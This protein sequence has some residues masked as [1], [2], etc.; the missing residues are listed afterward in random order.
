MRRLVTRI[1]DNQNEIVK[2]FRDNGA[3][4]KITS[5]VGQGFGDIIIGYKGVNVIVEIKDGSKSLSRQKLTKDE[6]KFRNGWQGKYAVINSKTK[7]LELLKSIDENTR[8]GEK[9]L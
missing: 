6:I 4:V 3:S 5:S 7:A 2:V 1:D 8:N 9:K